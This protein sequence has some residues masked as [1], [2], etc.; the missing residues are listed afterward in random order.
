MIPAAF[1]YSRAESVD[2]AIELLG[3]S[4]D[5]KVLAGGHSLLPLMKVRFAQPSLLVDI[6]RIG[7]LSYVREDGDVVAIGA[8]TRHHDVA[9]S[10]LL[11]SAC[12]IVPDTASQ[13][14]D[15]QVRHMGTIGGSIAH[16]DP[17]SDMGTVM[18]ALGAEFVVTSA[19][20]A[21]RTVAAGD[22]FK[23]LFT[24]D[25][26]PTELLTE[27]R[28]PKTTGGWSYLKFTRRAIDWAMVGVAAVQS[29]GGAR[30]ALT[31]M[32][33]RPL[34]AVGVEEALNGGSDPA[35][36]SARADEGAAPPS[37]AFGS[38][39]YRR[40]LSKVLVRR[41]LEEALA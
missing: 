19:G 31:N 35:A 34:R 11:Q 39:D 15:P 12:P 23:G 7:D 30:V 37:D 36:A 27:I 18:V 1:E 5:A 26:A 24:P 8:M 32:A 38:A 33:D 21:T 2:H 17:A 16:A 3:T 40:E 41:A 6:G 29:N 14:G 13:I 4:P 10:E 9:N 25:L 28:V 20:G 22:F